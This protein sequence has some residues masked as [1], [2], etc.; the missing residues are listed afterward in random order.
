METT[1]QGIVYPIL[2]NEIAMNGLDLR[3]IAKQ[4]GVRNTTL[5]RKLR[6]VIK[7]SLWEKIE[8]KR[9]LNSELSLESLFTR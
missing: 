5:M 9:L 4:I 2:M 6:G 8:I 1:G 3:Q 7:W